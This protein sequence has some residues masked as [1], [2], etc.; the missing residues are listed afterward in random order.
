MF[1]ETGRIVPQPEFQ[2]EV[3]P[4][5]QTAPT[6][7]AALPVFSDE[8]ARFVQVAAIASLEVDARTLL[9]QPLNWDLTGDEPAVLILHSHATEGYADT[10]NYRSSDPEENMVSIGAHLAQKLEGAGVHVIHDTK[11]HD[12]PSYDDAY[13]SARSSIAGYLAQY[14]SI[15][16]V[17]DLHRDATVDATGA[18]Y[19]QTVATKDG[20]AARLMLVMGTELGGQAHPLWQENLALA[21]KL[22]AVLEKQTPGLCKDIQLRSSRFNQDLSPG[23]LLVEVGAAGNSREEALAAVELLGD[24]ILSLA[25]GTAA[26][27]E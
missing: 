9:Q 12:L 14:P 17:L 20:N 6:E 5:V 3:Q 23:A 22:Q 25:Q 1:L 7:A 24:A 13:T 16:L 4:P 18:Q 27:S 8:D 19:G 11:L 21:A 26:Q 10:E 15:C 2:P